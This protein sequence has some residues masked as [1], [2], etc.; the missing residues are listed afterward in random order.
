MNL[1]LHEWTAKFE[2][3]YEVPEAAKKE[4]FE[5]GFYHFK[6]V[7]PPEMCDNLVRAINHQMGLASLAAKKQRLLKM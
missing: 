7:V 5:Q 1:I 2:P 3:R 6:N 4:L